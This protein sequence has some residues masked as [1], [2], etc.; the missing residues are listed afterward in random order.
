M[1]P[2]LPFVGRELELAAVRETCAEAG[3][4]I[5]IAEPGMGKSRLVEEL[6]AQDDSLTVL[7][8]V[9]ASELSRSPY[10]VF[11]AL[12]MQASRLLD[13]RDLGWTDEELETLSPVFPGLHTV[14]RRAEASTE[15]RRHDLWLALLRYFD[16]L[17]DG[18]DDPVVVVVEDLHV[19]DESSLAL[20]AWLSV[21]PV[22]IAMIGTTQPNVPYAVARLPMIG[23]RPLGLRALDAL[24]AQTGTTTIDPATLLDRT[25][26]S[27][28]RLHE[29]WL[30]ES[31]GKAGATSDAYLTRLLE[32]SPDDTIGTLRSMAV[33]PATL[34][35]RSLESAIETDRAMSQVLQEL[36]RLGLVKPQPDRTWAFADEGHRAAV[37]SSIDDTAR[38][39]IE[40]RLLERLG[41]RFDDR[42]ELLGH[43]AVIASDLGDRPGRAASLHLAAA[44]YAQAQLS[45]DTAREHYG[46]AVELA[47]IAADDQLLLDARLG[48]A[49]LLADASDPGTSEAL[50]PVYP[51]AK[52]LGD[53]DSFARAA[54]AA[55]VAAAHLG[56]PIA[57]DHDA[58]AVLRAAAAVVRDPELHARVL[59]ALAERSGDSLPPGEWDLSLIHI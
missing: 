43:A 17:A 26:G 45:P 34:D 33:F 4:A 40:R 59:L 24:L 11:R 9:G 48:L 47:E 2:T 32:G 8:A 14:D 12:A 27:P 37:L 53:G 3:T 46:S 30:D 31:F 15:E 50:A 25:G 52:R 5:V 42:P 39:H 19:V 13:P 55:P 23:L 29:W 44:R 57:V 54:L 22:G 7:M 51:L 36:E 28:M 18:V 10:A 41:D 21:Q 6:G 38:R 49:L 58:L 56:L 20:F 35:I 1:M 16:E